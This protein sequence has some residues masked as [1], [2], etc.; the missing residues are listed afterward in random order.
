MARQASGL[1]NGPNLY[2]RQWLIIKTTID[3]ALSD[4]VHIYGREVELIV[5]VA[6][7]AYIASDL[8][9]APF[10]AEISPQ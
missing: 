9:R 1:A 10:G 5:I 2:A 6:F 8:E 4:I 3:T 7:N